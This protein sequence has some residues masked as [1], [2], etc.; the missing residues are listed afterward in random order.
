MARVAR[1]PPTPRPE[2]AKLDRFSTP[3]QLP[4][5]T[6]F[7]DEP[8]LYSAKQLI[9]YI[10]SSAWLW[11]PL[12]ERTEERYEWGPKRGPGKW[13]LIYLAFVMS[14]IADVEPWYNKH[15]REDITLWK[16]CGF[17]RVPAYQT[18]WERFAELEERADAFERAARSLIRHARK[19]DLR[20]GAWWHVDATEAETHAAPVHDCLPHEPCPSR[21][22]V[23]IARLETGA[24]RELRQAAAKGPSEEDAEAVEVAGIR[25]EPIEKKIVDRKRGGVRFYS[26][27]HWWFSRDADAGT[28]AYTK[29]KTQ[30]AWHGF[31]NGKVADHYTGGPLAIYVFPADKQEYVAYP[32]MYEQAR[33]NVGADPLSVAGDKGHSLRAVYEYN[34]LRGVA[35]VFPYRRK[36]GSSPEQAEATEEWDE[37]GIPFCKHCRSGCDFVSFAVVDGRARLWFECAMPQT[38]AC[39]RVQT[40]SCSKDY[41][42]LLPLWRT[43]EAYGAMRE[44]HGEYER[45]HHLERVRYLVAPDQLAIRTKR[46]GIGV[47]QLRSSA[48]MFLEWLRICMRQGWI[49]RKGRRAAG[50]PHRPGDMLTNVAARRRKLGRTGGDRRKPGPRPRPRAQPP[51]RDDDYPF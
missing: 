5:A 34:T 36:N 35:S 48:A 6:A 51:P 40:I 20:V 30:R 7:S 49:G 37:H 12:L 32:T 33:S 9:A 13:A 23:R 42:R 50:H 2:P 21:R 1:V 31:Y 3:E 4:G 15:A 10:K 22:R 19:K 45:I 11:R 18:V 26:G 28:R 17:S 47:Q 43:S 16:L 25:A 14:G 27:G 44:S 38:D 24:V 29:G 46:I 41:A 39:E 8:D